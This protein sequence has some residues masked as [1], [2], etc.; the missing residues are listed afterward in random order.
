M[1]IA[2]LGPVL[3]SGLSLAAPASAEV[4][5]AG[6]TVND[7][8]VDGHL[9]LAA[10]DRTYRDR[11]K[12]RDHRRHPR[13]HRGHPGR[14]HGRHGRFG[15]CETWRYAHRKLHRRFPNVQLRRTVRNRRGHRIFIA[16]VR[17]YRGR[18]ARVRYNACLGRV[19][20]VA[21]LRHH[22]RYRRGWRR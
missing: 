9:T 3:A 10:R 7:G 21:P 5:S 20:K 19:M 6:V 18:P 22:P 13:R 17:S 11:R 16:H 12:H 2:I 15:R 1:K 14:G 4:L 8:R